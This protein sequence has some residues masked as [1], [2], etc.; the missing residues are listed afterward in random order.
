MVQIGE[1]K[2]LLRNDGNVNKLNVDIL[3]HVN[4]NMKTP[5]DTLTPFLFSISKLNSTK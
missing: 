4:K 3:V 1:K 5:K 2:S